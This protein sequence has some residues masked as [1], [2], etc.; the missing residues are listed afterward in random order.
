MWIP[1]QFSF[2]HKTQFHHGGARVSK[3]MVLIMAMELYWPAYAIYYIHLSM[4][5]VVPRRL[6]MRLYH[7]HVPL[8]T[9]CLLA[10][11]LC[12]LH[13][14]HSS[15]NWTLNIL[16][17]GSL[18][19]TLIRYSNGG[20]NRDADRSFIRYIGTVA[21]SIP[22]DRCLDIVLKHFTFQSSL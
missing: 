6:G 18:T 14:L 2:Q 3:W 8:R 5:S 21:N 15:R 1:I 9:V 12:S 19:H 4:H 10:I 20:P 17:W 22:D 7:I 11:S 16:V 13:S